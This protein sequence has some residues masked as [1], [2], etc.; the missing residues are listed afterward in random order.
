[1][2]YPTNHELTNDTVQIHDSSNGGEIWRWIKNK[3]TWQTVVFPIIYTH[4][5]ITRKCLKWSIYN[6]NNFKNLLKTKHS[7][8][9]IYHSNGGVDKPHIILIST[10]NPQIHR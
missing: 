2:E 5:D 7:Q 4:V 9:L 1:M 8:F 10:V 6:L 3:V